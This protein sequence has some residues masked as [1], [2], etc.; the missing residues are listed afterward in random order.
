M[1]LG[2]YYLTYCR[3]RPGRRRRSEE[4]DHAPEA[5][6]PPRTRSSSA[7]EAKQIEL[8]QPIEYRRNGEIVLTTPGPRDLQRRG[9]A[10][11]L[12]SR[13]ATTPSDSGRL[14]QPHALAR[15]RWTTSSPSS[16]T[17]TAPTSIAGVLDKIKTLGFHYAT[18]A[19]ITISKN[20]IVIPAV[21]EADPRRAT[22]SASQTLEA[23]VRARPHHRGGAPRVR[24]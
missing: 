2:G 7:V 5:R 8:Q 18:K 22:R 17:T 13:S 21:K 9:R 24:S 23:A 11:S 19:G 4:L 20:D 6:S 12:G 3:D 1:V 14:H 10:R 15:R 16:S